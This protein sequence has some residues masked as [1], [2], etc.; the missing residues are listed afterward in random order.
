MVDEAFGMLKGGDGSA[1]LFMGP[2]FSW[3]YLEKG[4][5]LY[6]SGGAS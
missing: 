5:D 2:R 3:W 1:C 4:W 6:L